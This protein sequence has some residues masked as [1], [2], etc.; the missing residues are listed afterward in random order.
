V[1]AAAFHIVGS[2]HGP[3]HLVWNSIATLIE[4]LYVIA[5]IRIPTERFPRQRR[6][7]AWWIVAG[8][9]PA[10]S[11]FG[12]FVPIGVLVAWPLVLHRFRYP[13]DAANENFSQTEEHERYRFYPGRRSPSEP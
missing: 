13:S 4:L 1:V 7:K 9:V 3:L 8:L 2:W 11:G 12:L 5:V 10:A 6:S